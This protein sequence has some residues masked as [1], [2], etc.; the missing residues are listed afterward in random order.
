MQSYPVIVGNQIAVVKDVK[1]SEM[2]NIWW[3][4][5]KNAGIIDEQTAIFQGSNAAPLNWHLLIIQT[6]ICLALP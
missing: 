6:N 1:S 2:L 3:K 4:N 5:Y